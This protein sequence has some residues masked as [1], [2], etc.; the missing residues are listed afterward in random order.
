MPSTG[1]RKNPIT[2]YGCSLVIRARISF[3]WA[4]KTT[5]AVEADDA[6]KRFA[7]LE[8]WARGKIPAL[9]DV[10]HR[11][12]G[13]VLDT[14]DYAGFIGRDPGR[15]TSTSRQ[16]IRTRPYP[17]GDG[18]DAEC[19]PGGRRRNQMGRLYSPER[20]PLKAAKN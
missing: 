1:T 16:A 19:G 14:I 11:W 3:W 6:G 17:R 4:A 20:K 15:S 9:K 10:T 8:A 5:K 12:S 13:Q 2:M 18:R 7:R